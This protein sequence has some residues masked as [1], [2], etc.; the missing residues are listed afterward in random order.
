MRIVMNER[1][2]RY[3]SL[4]KKIQ[5]CGRTVAV[6][7]A[8]CV[9]SATMQAFAPANFFRSD[10]P[11]LTLP[12]LKNQRGS[13]GLTVE[14]A[15]KSHGRDIKSQ[16]VN[17]LAVHDPL[18]AGA[19][20]FLNP[21]TTA[22]SSNATY[23]FATNTNP[24]IDN[25]NL[26]ANQGRGKLTF[27]GDHEEIDLNLFGSYLISWGKIP[28][29]MRFSLFV[30]VKS[31]K[32][33]H[34]NFTSLTP[35]PAAAPTSP[36][37]KA[38]LLNA[39]LPSVASAVGLD[40][41][42]VDRSGLGDVV[43]TLEWLYHF[44]EDARYFRNI[45]LRA[46]VGLSLPTAHEKDEDRA[47]DVPLGNDGSWGIPYGLSASVEAVEQLK[48]GLDVE[49]LSLLQ[50]TKVRRLKTHPAQTDFLLLN[51]GRA[52]KEPGMRYEVSPYIQV[53]GYEDIVSF[54]IGYQFVGHAKDKLKLKDDAFATKVTTDVRTAG[55]GL[56]SAT[57][58]AQ[59]VVSS[60][61]SLRK[62]H[63]HNLL[64][65]ANIDLAH[66]DRETPAAQLSFF[67]KPSIT[68]K[69]LID[70]DTIGGQLAVTF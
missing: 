27:D 30:P 61:N 29:E 46:K 1:D 44:R 50:R 22:L 19:H 14:A 57:A 42:P 45:T 41:T 40:L 58:T 49:F 26:P 63:V 13:L 62:W 38:G 47:F 52:R 70:S 37:E 10:D 39:N 54:K 69:H 21:A 43:G 48:I 25:L 67:F 3:A 64:L 33:R 59:D 11:L 2:A 53:L 16:H 15:V 35:K 31:R 36:D 7:V 6:L 56:V 34:F 18:Q 17:V 23:V 60:S 32:M 12:M 51:K 8:G 68:G 20:M 28:G 66:G 65:M 5:R 4:T 55:P 24:V 9:F